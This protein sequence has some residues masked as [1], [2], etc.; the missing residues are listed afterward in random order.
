MSSEAKFLSSILGGRGNRDGDDDFSA[1]DAGSFDDDDAEQFSTVSIKSPEDES[2]SDHS[3]DPPRMFVSPS[4]RL[5]PVLPTFQLKS[6]YKIHLHR[7]SSPPLHIIR[8]STPQ[9]L[10]TNPLQ[11]P[12]E[13][14][15]PITI[16]R[17][18]RWSTAHSIS[19]IEESTAV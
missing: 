11:S 15:S 4:L 3:S 12:V 16:L 18:T 6:Q 1:S 10:E 2:H 8:L 7:P 9:P 5:H 13:N 14:P 17:Q 19:N